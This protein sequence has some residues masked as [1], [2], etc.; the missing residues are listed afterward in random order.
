[1]KVHEELIEEHLVY[2]AQ[3]D[4][5]VRDSEPGML[6]HSLDQ[7]ASTC[8]YD[9]LPLPSHSWLTWHHM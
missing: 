6:Y 4:G 3:I 8:P 9:P 5:I 1:V 2:A 7:C